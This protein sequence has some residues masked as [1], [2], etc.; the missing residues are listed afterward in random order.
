MEKTLIIKRR[1]RPGWMRASAAL[2][3]MLMAAGLAP[4][5]A[6]QKSSRPSAPVAN[7]TTTAPD[8][9]LERA[10]RRVLGAHPLAMF[11]YASDTVGRGSLKAHARAITLLSPQ[12]FWIDAEGFVHGQLPSHVAEMAGLAG[13]PLM[14]LL[15]NP[16]FDRSIAHALLHDAEAQ[17]RAILYLASL[18]KRDNFVGWQLDIENIDP[19]DKAEYVT[20]V[21]RAAMRMHRDQRLLSVAVVPRFSDT[22]PDTAAPGFHTGEW[23]APFDYR[24]LGRIADFVT[25]MAYDQH[26]S[27]T[28][29]GPVAGYDWVKAALDYAAERVPPA[30]LVLG[31]PF[32]GR[33]W[34]ETSEGTKSHSLMFKDLKSYRES[35]PHWDEQSRTTWFGVEDGATKRTAW[36]DDSRSLR[37]KLS[38]I[39]R[40]HLRGF[41]AWRLG[42]EDPGFWPMAAQF[43][44][45]TGTTKKV[46]GVSP[47]SGRH[48]VAHGVS[49]G[50]AP[51]T[52]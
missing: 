51:E 52:E 39:E 23:G 33:A 6:R 12:G 37:E 2:G 40:Y 9:S 30:K 4:G 25:L 41:A 1:K 5:A 26:S 43:G 28:P 35:D 45:R 16:G 20:F 34:E 7:K 11:Y 47:R 13:L 42:V 49:H 3:V 18:A 32:Y 14:P 36:F 19:E 22:F 27:L 24:E 46:K 44:K 48:N 50:I 15:A 17:E 8:A 21:E 38:L 10:R 29:P 31:L